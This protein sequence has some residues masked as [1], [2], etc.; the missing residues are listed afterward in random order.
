MAIILAVV[1][2]VAGAF[3]GARAM[4]RRGPEITDPS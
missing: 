1:V 3:V 4:R 2:L